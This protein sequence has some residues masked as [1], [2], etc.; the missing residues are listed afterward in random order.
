MRCAPSC[1]TGRSPT[2]PRSSGDPTASPARSSTA[3]TADASSATTANLSQDHEASCPT[4]CMPAGSSGSDL[5]PG[6]P[7]APC[8]PPSLSAPTRPSTGTSAASRAYVLDRT[9]LDLY[10][11]RVAAEFVSAL[12]PTLR[13]ES[14][15]ALV[16][17]MTQD[18]A[19]CREILSAIVPS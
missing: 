10:G 7:T 13:L 3:T 12:R 18:V 16:E 14:I 11:E 9:D 2:Q 15:D 4:A 17:Q 5:A 6:V 8:P 19:R 1:S